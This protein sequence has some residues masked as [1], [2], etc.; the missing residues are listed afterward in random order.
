MPENTK[1]A[2]GVSKKGTNNVEEIHIQP[3][4]TA[5]SAI[6]KFSL[7][8][9]SNKVVATKQLEWTKTP[10]AINISDVQ[11][12]SNATDGTH[13]QVVIK[14]EG[15][16]VKIG[17]PKITLQGKEIEGDPKGADVSPGKFAFAFELSSTL[18]KGNYDLEL[19]LPR[20]DGKPN[21]SL[22]GELKVK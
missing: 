19:T 13:V 2:A 9:T 14:V 21:V 18:K 6:V 16:T 3:G 20:T 7:L 12:F 15:S 10:S 8:D 1:F 5:N 17:T 22:K 4:T 11:C